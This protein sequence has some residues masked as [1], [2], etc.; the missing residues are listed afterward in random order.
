MVRAIVQLKNNDLMQWTKPLAYNSK[1]LSP[2]MSAS[3]PHT[4]ERCNSESVSIKPWQS[5]YYHSA[6]NGLIQRVNEIN[7]QLGYIIESNK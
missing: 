3:Y 6:T 2:T 7:R 4:P 1:R 5:R